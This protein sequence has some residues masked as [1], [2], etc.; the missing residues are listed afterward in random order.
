M[1]DDNDDWKQEAIAADI[2][3]LESAGWKPV[4]FEVRCDR[5]DW[6]G[7]ETDNSGH[8]LTPLERHMCAA[9]A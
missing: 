5:C 9:H 7:P 4:P 2:R 1:S 8:T 3:A 6:I